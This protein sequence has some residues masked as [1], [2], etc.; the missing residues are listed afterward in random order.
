MEKGTWRGSLKMSRFQET[1]E[2]KLCRGETEEMVRR[3]MEE[4]RKS[5]DGENAAAPLGFPDDNG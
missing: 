2:E 1:E 5:Q 3:E 4:I